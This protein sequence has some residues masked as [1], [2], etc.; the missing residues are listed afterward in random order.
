MSMME[1][2]IRS[3]HLEPME[4]DGQLIHIVID[5]TEIPDPI[6]KLTCVHTYP[7]DLIKVVKNNYMQKKN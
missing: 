7:L 3:K 6:R 1:H 5:Y 4:S 2:N